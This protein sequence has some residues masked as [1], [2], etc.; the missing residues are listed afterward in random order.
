MIMVLEREL[1]TCTVEKKRPQRSIREVR[2][3]TKEIKMG[4]ESEKRK[5]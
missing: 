4:N 1:N 2:I 3:E 5:E